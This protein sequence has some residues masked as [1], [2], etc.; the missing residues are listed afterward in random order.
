MSREYNIRHVVR[1]HADADTK[2]NSAEFLFTPSQA[3]LVWWGLHLLSMEL[4]K[5]IPGGSWEDYP[6]TM[7]C[8]ADA[9]D[10][11]GTAQERL[12]AHAS[13]HKL[14]VSKA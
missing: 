2:K 14:E 13:K 6:D 10:W 5:P 4:R 3:C 7:R 11:V 9:I 1:Q 12:A 8:Y